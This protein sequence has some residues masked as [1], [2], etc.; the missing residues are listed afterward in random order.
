MP[1]VFRHHMPGHEARSGI[2][3]L[4]TDESQDAVTHSP[5]ITITS[6]PIHIDRVIRSIIAQ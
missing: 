1:Y 5:Q 4:G 6:S 2:Q 3:Y